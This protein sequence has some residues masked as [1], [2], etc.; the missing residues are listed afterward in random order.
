MLPEGTT[1]KARASY[2]GPAAVQESSRIP[3]TGLGSK[4]PHGLV[5]PS[6]A[7]ACHSILVSLYLRAHP[8]TQIPISPA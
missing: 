7:V 2:M 1:A 3:W 6:Y 8:A 5:S 4:H